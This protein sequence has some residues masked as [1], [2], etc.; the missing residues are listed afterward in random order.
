M[1]SIITK[2][3]VDI[4]QSIL[5]QVAT[6]TETE[7][8]VIV[9][10]IVGAT[11]Y[12]SY[13]RIWPTTYLFDRHSAHRSDLVYAENISYYPQWQEVPVGKGSHFTLIFSKLPKS[14]RVF[15]LREVIPASHPFEVLDIQRNQTDVYFVRI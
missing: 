5:D 3:K 8:Q 12:P 7:G 6:M 13:I 1:P 9:H 10:C 4:D 2:P 15:D 11:R 14:C